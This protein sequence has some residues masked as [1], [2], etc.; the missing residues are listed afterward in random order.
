MISAGVLQK[1]GK[2]VRAG[3][4]APN[5]NCKNSNQTKRQESY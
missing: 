3:L 4:C 5:F 2:K 1:K